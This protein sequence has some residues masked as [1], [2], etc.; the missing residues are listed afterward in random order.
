MTLGAHL[1]ELRWRLMKPIL[2]LIILV[3]VG[4]GFSAELKL[5]FEHPLRQALELVDPE[6]LAALGIDPDPDKPL[7]KALSLVESPIN[8]IKVSLFAAVLITFPFFVLQLWRFVA[9][10]LSRREK[11][12]G[13]WLLPA[14]VI[15]FY[16][17]TVFGYFLGLPWFYKF[18]I[19]FTAN[20]HVVVDLRESEYFS[21]FT[22]LTLAFG[23]IMDIPWL[24]MVLVRAKL[25]TPE[26]IA[27]KRKIILVI[28]AVLAAVLSPP[29]PVSQIVL[30]GLML[31]LFEVGLIMCRF[32]VSKNDQLIAEDDDQIPDDYI[33]EPSPAGNGPGDDGLV[34]E[35]LIGPEARKSVQKSL[36]L[37]TETSADKQV[38]DANNSQHNGDEAGKSESH[39]SD[40][41]PDDHDPWSSQRTITRDPYA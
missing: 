34:Y 22:M 41:D 21:F 19:D 38:E 3:I 2:L 28:I 40:D 27:G 7:L 15:F 23:L 20:Y 13:F 25:L 37:A 18:S 6:N 14:A 35:D 8:A 33:E 12:A 1:E 17:G 4:F 31:I 30:I 24:M 9:P 5:M 36:P 32:M 10:A 11:S 29:D 39:G 26:T 16:G